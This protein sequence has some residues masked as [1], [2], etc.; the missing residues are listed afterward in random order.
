MLGDIYNLNPILAR[1]LFL[2][3]LRQRPNYLS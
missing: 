1:E 2:A 3:E